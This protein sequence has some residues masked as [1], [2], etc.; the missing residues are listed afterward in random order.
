MRIKIAEFIGTVWRFGVHALGF[1]M[2][3]ISGDVAFRNA[4]DTDYVNV[5]GKDP[6]TD[7]DFATRRYVDT[8]DG[9]I[10]VGRQAD[11]SSAIPNNTSTRG[12]VVPTT[13]GSGVVK[14][15]LLY[16]DGSGSGQMTII[17]KT[18]GQ[19]ISTTVA[20]TGGTITFDPNSIYSWDNEGDTW[21]KI[22]DIGSVVGAERVIRYTIDNSPS[23]SS[24]N[25]I[26]ANARVTYTEV[27]VTTAYSAGASLTV[28]HS[29][30]ADLLFGA[31]SNDINL[32]RTG[33]YVIPQNT[34]WGS[35]ARPPLTTIGGSPAAGAGAVTVKFTE[36]LG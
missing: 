18:N 12:F 17:G 23:Q 10:V 4:D 28:G 27:E 7:D 29:G 22:G 5:R 21:V 20:L 1:L 2:K 26:P 36:P 32:Q 16:D 13:F 15:D 30:D 3:N 19:A 6:Q 35:T 25:D 33:K 9:T 8:R 34:A 11:T 14:G 31:D 24:V